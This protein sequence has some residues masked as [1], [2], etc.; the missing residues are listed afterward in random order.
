MEANGRDTAPGNLPTENGPEDADD[1]RQRL[2]GS[3]TEQLAA[4]AAARR[5]ARELAL[6]RRLLRFAG[7]EASAPRAR[8]PAALSPVQRALPLTDDRTCFHLDTCERQ[9]AH[10]ILSGWAFRAVP[11]WDARAAT[12]TIHLRNDTLAYAAAAASVPRPDVAAHYAAQGPASAGGAVGL[13]A[14]GFRCDVVNDS[15]PEGVELEVVLRLDCAGLSC[16]QPT[17]RRLRF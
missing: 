9:G 6:A 10:T 7:G 1:L 3:Q 17:G 5:L 16:E 11:G 2:Q 13:E 8:K 15:L 4:R 12:V 14:A